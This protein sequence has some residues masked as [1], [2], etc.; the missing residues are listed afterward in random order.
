MPSTKSLVLALALTAPAA[1]LVPPSDGSGGA[2]DADSPSAHLLGAS[3]AGAASP[4]LWSTVSPA[5]V[6]GFDPAWA[7]HVRTTER[8]GC[9]SFHELEAAAGDFPLDAVLAAGP[10][11]THGKDKPGLGAPNSLKLP[12]S[13]LKRLM[14]FDGMIDN[15][16]VRVPSAQTIACRDVLMHRSPI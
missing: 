16:D 12:L 13:I 6:S 9:L 7:A 10:L 8:V 15:C 14:E 1:A 3:T 11:C 2:G 5:N 4:G